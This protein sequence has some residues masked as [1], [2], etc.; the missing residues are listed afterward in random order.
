MLQ[1]QGGF[2]REIVGYTRVVMWDPQM[3]EFVHVGGI[4]FDRNAK[5]YAQNNTIIYRFAFVLQI[6]Q[7]TIKRYVRK[8]REIGNVNTAIIGRPYNCIS[9]HP[10]EELV[11]MR[12]CS[13]ILKI[14]LPKYRAK[15]T[16][17]QDRNMHAQLCTI[18]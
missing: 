10:H 1:N 13:N 16:R 15:S 3:V 11:I 8:F 17:R 12:W 5:I 18:I 9:M 7:S 6:S 2:Q 4:S 14:P